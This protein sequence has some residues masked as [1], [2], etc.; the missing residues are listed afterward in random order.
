MQLKSLNAFLDVVF[1]LI[2]FRI[3]EYLPSF[4]GTHWEQLPNGLLGLLASQPANLTRV[5]F[6]VIMV[7][8]CWSRKNAFLGLLSRSNAVL[9]T[10]AIGALFFVCLFMYALVADPTYA[11]GPPTLLLQSISVFIASLLAYVALRY[12]VHAGLVEPDSLGS[13]QKIAWNDLTNPITALIATA[14]S[15]S[16]L[17]IWTLSWFILMPLISWLLARAAPKAA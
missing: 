11:G 2:F 17:T 9:D 5:V 14:L 1:A 4:A 6:G 7:A 15:W 3:V 13:A 12:A 8:Y 10:L 16:G